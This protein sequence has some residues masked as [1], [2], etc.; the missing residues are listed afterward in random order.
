MIDQETQ[1]G[2]GCCDGGG[3]GTDPALPQRS[4]QS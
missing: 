3:G 4:T 2:G 1:G